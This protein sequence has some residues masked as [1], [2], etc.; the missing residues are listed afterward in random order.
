MRSSDDSA[1]NDDDDDMRSSD[2]SATNDDDDDMR[3]SDDSATNNDDDD[4]MR[5]SDDSATNDDDDDMRSSDDSATNDMMRSSDDSATNDDDDDDMRSSDDDSATNDDDDDMRSSDDSAT[6]DDDDDMRSSDDSATNDDDDDMR[7]SDDS[8]TNDDDDDLRSSDD[9]ATND[10]DDDMRSSDDPATNDDDMRSSDDSATNDD[11]MRSSDDSATNDDDDDVAMLLLLFSDGMCHWSNTKEDSDKST[12]YR[13]YYRPRS[14]DVEITAYALLTLSLNKD[15]KNGLPVDTVLGIQAMSEFAALI[16]SSSQNFQVKLS[17]S[18]DKSFSKSFTVNTGNAMVLQQVLISKVEG[19]LTVTANGRGIGML[20]V[21][22]TYHVDKAPDKS[23]FNFV[24][25]ILNQGNYEIET[26]SCAKWQGDG[27]DSDMAVMELGVV[28]GFSPSQDAIDKLL[29]DKKLAVKRIDKEAKKLVLY[30]DKIN[31]AKPTCV[32]MRYE[33]THP[34]GKSQPVPAVVYDYYNPGATVLQD[35]RL[36]EDGSENRQGCGSIGRGNECQVAQNDEEN[37]PEQ[38]VEMKHVD[39]VIPGIMRNNYQPVPLQ[40]DKDSLRKHSN[41]KKY[42]EQE[43]KTLSDASKPIDRRVK[44]DGLPT[45]FSNEGI[46][47]PL[48]EPESD[49]TATEDES[50]ASRIR[51]QNLNMHLKGEKAKPDEPSAIDSQMTSISKSRFARAKS[52]FKE[53]ESLLVAFSKTSSRGSRS[54]DVDFYRLSIACTILNCI[55]NPVLGLRECT[56]LITQ[57]NS[58]EYVQRIFTRVLG[59]PRGL[60]ARLTKKFNGRKRRKVM[61]LVHF[62]NYIVWKWLML[63]ASESG[64]GQSMGIP[65]IESGVGPVHPT[66]DWCVRDKCQTCVEFVGTIPSSCTMAV[67]SKDQ[68]VIIDAKNDVTVYTVEGKALL[69]FK[70]S[71]PRHPHSRWIIGLDGHDNI[72]VG[73]SLGILSE[74]KHPLSVFTSTGELLGEPELRGC[75]GKFHLYAVTRTSLILMLSVGTPLGSIVSV[76]ERDAKLVKSFVVREITFPRYFSAGKDTIIVGGTTAKASQDFAFQIF[77]HLGQQLFFVKPE[78][79]FQHCEVDPWTGS[80]V[81]VR[82]DTL[83]DYRYCL[84]NTVVLTGEIHV[85][86]PNGQTIKS[87]INLRWPFRVV[88]GVT[89][90]KCGLVAVVTMDEPYYAIH[91]I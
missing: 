66:D 30:F 36:S 54:K 81:L 27:D 16:Y 33:R 29:K 32:E 90:L 25:E 74:T 45:T 6:N 42:K 2:D 83:R 77:D 7:S 58:L 78:V 34:V 21:G 5:S 52:K 79:S 64:S 59:N 67:N 23:S 14:A 80:I 9:P 60:K 10:D 50:D 13:P 26:K 82:T 8:A 18:A 15:T 53:V 40:I 68:L 49:L 39:P 76:H 17:Q 4:D 1:T 31:K 55:D 72:Y 22:V 44:K 71:T 88:A 73:S 85:L 38:A 47:V 65:A 24:I 12:Q 61:S 51:D 57:L 89:V 20:Q 35:E 41:E 87:S 62:T 3:S 84:C 48:C 91:V 69:S 11:D 75:R 28:S 56:R 43:K 37:T 19:S 63:A 46:R 70:A 86:A